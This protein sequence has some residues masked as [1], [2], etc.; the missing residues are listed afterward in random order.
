M[1]LIIKLFY[2]RKLAI[3]QCQ[4]YAA[5]ISFANFTDNKKLRNKF[6][7]NLIKNLRKKSKG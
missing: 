6:K 4:I 5:D 7:L 2:R 1:P 3:V